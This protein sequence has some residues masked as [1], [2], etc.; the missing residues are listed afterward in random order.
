M[1]RVLLACE[2]SQA[3]TIAMRRLGIEAYSCDIQPCSGGHPEWHI[4]GDALPLLEEQWDLI[5]AFPPCTHLS[6]SGARWWPEKRADGRQQ[7]AIDFFLKFAHARCQRIV[8]ENTPGIM[9]SVWRKP[10]QVVYPWMF[11]D[12]YQK[13]VCLWL[14]NLPPLRP[15]NVVDRGEFI[16]LS[17]GR[18]MAKWYAD[19]FKLPAEDRWKVRSRLFPG[20]AQAMAEQWGMFVHERLTRARDKIEAS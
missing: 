20:I 3:V 7:A 15:T 1:T 13:V 12:S 6:A 16:T 4:Q 14:K 11:G 2:E 19:A 18:R 8:I 9:T 10:D 17:S 5:I